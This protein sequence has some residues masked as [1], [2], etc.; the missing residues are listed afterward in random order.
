MARRENHRQRLIEGALKCLREKGYAHT[1]ARDIAAAS[2]ANLGSIGYHF[3][4]K[5]ALLREALSE[6]L[7]QWT[8]YFLSRAHAHEG[9]G[10][11]EHLRTFWSGA[12]ESVQE[13]QGLMLALVEALPAAT[14]SPILRA[15]LSDLIEETRRVSQATIEAA[16]PGAQALDERT[17]RTLASLLIAVIDGL[18]LQWLIDPERAPTGEELTGVLD[19]ILPSATRLLS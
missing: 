8:Q 13:Q 9:A 6:G 11:L 4:S 3:G 18:A 5:D 19:S 7:R 17:A 16:I 10:P 2:N 15:Q 14:R 1:T 12:A